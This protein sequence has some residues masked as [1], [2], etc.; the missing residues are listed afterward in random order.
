MSELMNTLLRWGI[1][2][3]ISDREAFVQKTAALLEQYRADPDQAQ[4]LAKL[5]TA[6]LEDK[7]ENLNAKRMIKKFLAEGKVATKD[8]IQDLKTT[9]EELANEFHQLNKRTDV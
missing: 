3:G 5:L 2:A 6:Y 9:L 8:D 4:K 1:L 7:K